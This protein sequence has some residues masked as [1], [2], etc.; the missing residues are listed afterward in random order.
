[1]DRLN[2]LQINQLDRSLAPYDGLRARKLPDIGWVKTIRSTLGMSIRQLADRT[3]LSKTSI[4]SAES[5]EAKGSIRLDTLKRVAHGLDCELVYAIVPQKSLRHTLEKQA[6]RK[7]VL[8]VEG[9]SDSMDLEAQGISNK[10]RQRQIE[11]MAEE[12]LRNRGRGFWDV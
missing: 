2:D 11:E 3:G 4:S 9:V 12:M 8:L 6:K 1:M 5:S 7:A 10:E